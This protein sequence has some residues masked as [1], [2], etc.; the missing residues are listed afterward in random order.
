MQEKIDISKNQ[1]RVT[2]FGT[3][4]EEKIPILKLLS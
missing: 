4:N 3:E 2:I 1:S